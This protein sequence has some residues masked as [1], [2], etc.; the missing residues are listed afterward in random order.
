MKDQKLNDKIDRVRKQLGD[1]AVHDFNHYAPEEQ[2][3]ARDM[4]GT[5]KALLKQVK[6]LNEIREAQQELE[7]DPL[8]VR[9]GRVEKQG[10][11]NEVRIGHLEKRV[12]NAELRIQEL[13]RKIV[14]GLEKRW[15]RA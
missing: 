4:L 5:I 14:T 6:T 12:T 10:S 9:C 8:V 13:D 2:R 11:D 1:I 7:A 15:D 3:L